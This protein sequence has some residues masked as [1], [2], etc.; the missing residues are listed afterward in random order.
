MPLFELYSLA[1]EVPGTDIVPF[2]VRQRAIQDGTH[3]LI[4]RSDGSETVYDLK[5]DPDERAPLSAGE[6][7]AAAGPLRATLGTWVATR[8]KTVNLPTSNH[9]E[10]DSNTLRSLRALGYVR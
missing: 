8:P 1:T 5:Q 4:V 6:G 10:I 9:V 3:K 7:E 2:A